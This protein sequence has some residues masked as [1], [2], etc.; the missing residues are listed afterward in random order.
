MGG[1]T[2]ELF[3]KLVQQLRNLVPVDAVQGTR[4][5]HELD[6]RRIDKLA[7]GLGAYLNAASML[8]G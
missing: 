6:T 7:P 3:Q 1:P 5:V 8:V 2:V 4:P